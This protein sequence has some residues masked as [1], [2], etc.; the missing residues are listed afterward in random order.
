VPI[1][2]KFPVT[3]ILSRKRAVFTDRRCDLKVTG[4]NSATSDEVSVTFF[5][6]YTPVVLQENGSAGLVTISGR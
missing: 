3:T 1:I 4:N 5:S 6:F 2:E